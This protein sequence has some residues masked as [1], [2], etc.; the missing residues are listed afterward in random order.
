MAGRWCAPLPSPRVVG[1]CPTLLTPPSHRTSN[2]TGLNKMV[3]LLAQ[4]VKT[5]ECVT[6]REAGLSVQS[7]RRGRLAGHPDAWLGAGRGRGASCRAPER[8]STA[9]GG[10]GSHPF[11]PM[12]SDTL[13]PPRSPECPA[14]CPPSPAVPVLRPADPGA[15]AQSLRTRGAHPLSRP[16][17]VCTLASG[18]G[19]RLS[20]TGPGELRIGEALEW[21]KSEACPLLLYCGFLHS[22]KPATSDNTAAGL[23]GKRA[24]RGLIPDP[25]ETGPGGARLAWRPSEEGTSRSFC[26]CCRPGVGQESDAGP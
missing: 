18:Q 11:R 24:G 8:H 14:Q 26:A 23:G 6:L 3:T 25:E 16:S 19:G 13:G 7:P 12:A 9:Q 4:L 10:A 21:P 17:G 5:P 22:G 15:R 1:E 20:T 2:S